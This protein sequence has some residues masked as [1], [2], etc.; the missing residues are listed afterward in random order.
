MPSKHKKDQNTAEK[1]FDIIV[2]GGGASGMM[3]AGRAAELGKK[4]LLLEKNTQLG[5]KLKITGGGRCNVTNA[6]SNVST[7]L[8]NYGIAEDF[9]YSPFSKFAG[10]ETFQFFDKRNLSLVVQAGQRA[11][12][13]TEKAFDVFKVMEKYLREGGVS[14]KTNSP[15]TQ[16]IKDGDKITGVKVQDKIYSAKSYILATGGMS[17]PE[18]G[19]TGDGF[20]WLRVLGHNVKTPTPTIVPIK[21]KESWVKS[22]PGTVFPDIKIT[23]SLDGIKKFFKK[24]N[25][26]CTHFGL[27]GPLILNSAGQVNDLLYEGAVTAKIDMFPSLDEAQLEAKL[28]QTFEENKNKNLKNALSQII[29]T[30]AIESLL[31]LVPNLEQDT[32]VHSVTK[33]NRKSL[34]TLFKNLSVTVTGLMG[35]DKAVV[36]DGGVDLSEIDMKTMQSK[37]IENLYI[38]GDLLHINRPSG[39]YSLQICWTSGYIAGCNA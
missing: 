16:I 9:L 30:G 37:K 4:V 2:I 20:D 26:L 29:P 7:F 8:K 15:V 31:S 23:F 33:E 34:I 39:G 13:H 5:E 12:P 21:V 19:S 35:F 11:F 32:K 22:I 1:N 17:H 3:S 27:S 14:I 6:E 18:T 36:A 24:G 25:I 10:K 28:L 38:T